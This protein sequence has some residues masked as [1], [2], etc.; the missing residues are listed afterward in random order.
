MFESIE[1]RCKKIQFR[2]R[3]HALGIATES[4]QRGTSEDLK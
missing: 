3:M 4:P 2:R 1:F